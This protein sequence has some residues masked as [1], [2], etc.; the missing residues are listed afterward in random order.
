MGNNCLRLEPMAVRLELPIPAKLRI[1]QDHFQ[2]VHTMHS[3]SFGDISSRHLK[4]MKILEEVFI[5][6]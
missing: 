6:L 1:A 3:D 4:S 2:N 5:Y